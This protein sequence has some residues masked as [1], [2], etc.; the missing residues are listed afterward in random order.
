M[1]QWVHRYASQWWGAWAKPLIRSMMYSVTLCGTIVSYN[2]VESL[3]VTVCPKHTL[4]LT[5]GPQTKAEARPLRGILHQHPQ[6]HCGHKNRTATPL[7]GQ[8]QPHTAPVVRY[9]PILEPMVMGLTTLRSSQTLKLCIHPQWDL[10]RVYA[11]YQKQNYP[12]STHRVT[13]WGMTSKYASH[14]TLARH[15]PLQ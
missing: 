13:V 7:R 8:L 14:P 3:N 10:V 6:G 1:H 5:A 11:S 4:M 12:I 2:V 9:Y 15:S